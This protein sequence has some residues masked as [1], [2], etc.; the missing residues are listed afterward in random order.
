M[1]YRI[2][3]DDVLA[4]RIFDD[5]NPNE[6]GAPFL[7]QPDQ[8]DANPWENLESAQEWADAFVADLLAPSPEPTEE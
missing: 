6:N 3:I 8:P 1:R 4:V 5:E 2:E 7:Y